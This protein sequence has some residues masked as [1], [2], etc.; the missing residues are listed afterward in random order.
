MKLVK[1]DRQK[2]IIKGQE[3]IKFSSSSSYHLIIL[4]ARAKGEKQISESSTD[5]EELTLQID[6]KTFPKLGS[7]SNKVLD[8][9]ASINGGRLHNLSKTVYFLVNLS[10]KDHKIILNTDDPPGTATFESLEI[11]T[12]DPTNILTLE[13]KIQAEDGDRREW[14]TFVL[15]NTPLVDVSLTIT[16]SRRK[17]D[18]DDVKIRID[19]QTQ[20]NI[21]RDIKH[22][23]WYF[24]GSLIPLISSTRTETQTFTTNFPSGL[25]YIELDADRMPTLNSI[26]IKLGGIITSKDS[27]EQYQDTKFGH[28]Y[29]KLD[30]Y[31][32]KATE[33]WNNFFLNQIYPPTELLDPNLIKAILY[34][35]SKLGYYPDEDIIDVMQVWDS[36]NPARSTLLGETPERE[37]VRPDKIEFI[38]K[39]YPE[40]IIPKVE[41]R[42]ESILWG[43]RWLYHK[44]QYLLESDDGNTT[45]PYVRKWRSWKE[46]V[47]SYNANPNLVDEYVK[48]VFSIY[49]KGV[50]SEGNILW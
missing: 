25:H 23:L 6:N 8:S 36:K 9:P 38:H 49:D 35:E 43:I 18:S 26:E 34:R 40:G 45:V 47:R 22:F 3:E 27:I 31:I 15:D 44:A 4:T 1:E 17:R 12:L 32:I 28:D 50:D 48:E 39:F 21:L 30:E 14:I 19:G 41:D 20:S 11:Y 46:A 13:P 5:D 10:G 33:F 24:A 2:R 42:E 29:N 7:N 16:Y 37:F